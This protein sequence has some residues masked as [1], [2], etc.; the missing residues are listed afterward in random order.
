[1]KASLESLQTRENREKGLYGSQV[2]T[3]N[4]LASMGGLY[5]VEDMDFERLNGP[6]NGEWVDIEEATDITYSIRDMEVDIPKRKTHC[7]TT[8]AATG[9]YFECIDAIR[10][11]LYQA[12]TMWEIYWLSDACNTLDNVMMSKVC[13][14]EIR[15]TAYERLEKAFNK[16]ESRVQRNKA[17]RT[18]LISIGRIVPISARKE[19]IVSA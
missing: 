15:K 14:W 10:K 4:Y 6:R 19:K 11:L 2:A 9:F 16:A 12:T 3:Q 1:M 13:W 18:Y 8:R 5:P 17:H 7:F